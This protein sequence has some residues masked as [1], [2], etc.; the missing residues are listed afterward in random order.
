[1]GPVRDSFVLLTFGEVAGLFLLI[2]VMFNVDCVEQTLE[3]MLC[4]G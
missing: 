2:I 1:M 3:I 4:G